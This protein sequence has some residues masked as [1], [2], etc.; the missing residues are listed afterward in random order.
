ML[1]F[2]IY[3]ISSFSLSFFKSSVHYVWENLYYF[4]IQRGFVLVVGFDCFVFCFFFVRIPHNKKKLNKQLER[5]QHF[6]L[7]FDPYLST[8]MGPKVNI[9]FGVHKANANIT[10]HKIASSSKSCPT[11]LRVAWKYAELIPITT[12]SAQITLTP[13]HT[14]LE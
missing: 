2:L 13:E 12:K 14:C 10:P 11:R 7:Y 5:Q 8:T 9:H 3:L 6:N 1:I 4:Q